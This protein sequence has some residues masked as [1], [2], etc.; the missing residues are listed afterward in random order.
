MPFY[1]YHMQTK[2]NDIFND[3]KTDL[4]SLDD[5]AR[6][7]GEDVAK[8]EK[9]VSERASFTKEQALQLADKFGYVPGFFLGVD[10]PGDWVDAQDMPAF[11]R[12]MG[13]EKRRVPIERSDLSFIEQENLITRSAELYFKQLAQDK[14]PG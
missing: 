6:Y 12:F 2:F 9:I 8:V 13:N 1:K 14:Y 11:E 4:H 10:M 7:L 3:N 5:V